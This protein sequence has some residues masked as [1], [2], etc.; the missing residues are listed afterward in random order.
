MELIKR[1]DDPSGIV[2]KLVFE[3]G[4]AIAET[5]VYKY[6][7]RGV[8]CFSCQS[9]CP[10]GCVFCGT[11]NQFIRNLTSFEMLQQIGEGL[12]RLHG[13]PKIQVMSMS[14][15][16][17]MLNWEEVR[18]VSE[19]ILSLEHDFFISTVGID[20]PRVFEDIMLLGDT[21]YNFGLQFSLHKTDETERKKLFRGHSFKLCTI[22]QLLDRGRE[23]TLKTGRKAYYNY[24][25]TGKE[26]HSEE[27]LRFLAWELKGMHLTCSVLCNTC[28]PVKAS[29]DHAERLA[30]RIDARSHGKV[31]VSTFDPVGQ[32]TIGG[33]C[34]QLFYVQEKLG[35]RKGVN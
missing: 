12:K 14:M 22:N 27:T 5:V 32:D 10:I 15:G 31:E 9:G 21:H 35:R 3:E 29:V 16:E 20:E 7:D 34:G 23:F 28:S 19:Y 30:R 17:P 26:Y 11:G 1:L 24:V 18:S 8:I 25:C 4:D 2:S 13:I 6:Q 33:G